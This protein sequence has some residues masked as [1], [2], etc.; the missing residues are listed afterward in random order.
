[1]DN[2]TVIL[3][4]IE[5]EQFKRFQEHF[6]L[7]TEME[8]CKVFEIQYGKAIFNFAGGLLQNIVREEMVYKR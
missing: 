6:N 2:V 4:Q 8:R 7:F 5:A 3:T 1:M